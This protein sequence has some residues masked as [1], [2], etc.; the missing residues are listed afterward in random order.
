M[1]DNLL[2][3]LVTRQTDTPAPLEGQD[4]PSGEGMSASFG[5]ASMGTLGV[6]LGQHFESGGPTM[7]R[8]QAA[9]VMKENGYDASVL[10]DG[11]ISQG[12][13]DAV[14]KQQGE[15]QRDRDMAA[16]AH[17]G[18]ATQFVT[19]L[20]GSMTDPIFLALG[21]AG[22]AIQA[23]RGAV[24]LGEAAEGATLAV[25]A[26]KGAAEGGAVIGGYETTQKFVGTGQGDRDI[27]TN[28]IVRDATIGAV[29]GGTL[30]AAFGARPKPASDNA[31][32]SI[33][34]EEGGKTTD[35]GGR[36]NFGI[37]QKAHPEIDIDNLTVSQARDI[38][39]T[40][41]WDKIGGD[42]LPANMQITAL[43]AAVN[44]GTG[45]A[46]LWLKEANGDPIKFNALRRAD[47]VKLA[48]DQPEVYGKYLKGWLAR[49]GRVSLKSVNPY[50]PEQMGPAESTLAQNA[51]NASRGQIGP[52]SRVASGLEVPAPEAPTPRGEEIA[53]AETLDQLGKLKLPTL[54]AYPGYAPISLGE[55]MAQLRARGFD[56]NETA[57][58]AAKTAVL[59]A[60]QDSTVNV[61]PLLPKAP[62][63][64]ANL[65][66]AVP[67]NGSALVTPEAQASL[68]RVNNAAKM[69]PPVQT[70][71]ATVSPETA[72][73]KQQ[74]TEAVAEAE[75]AHT[76][77]NGIPTEEGAEPAAPLHAALSADDEAIA[78]D[79]TLAKA[80]DAAVRCGSMKGLV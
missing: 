39:K 30:G 15:I 77:A 9:K 79:K 49:L 62:G 13:L 75:H 23:V 20:A 16:R 35:T 38:Y 64:A 24:G 7:P 51:E 78:Q 71:N 45:K 12:Y 46:I 31:I 61:D 59:Q 27:T 69:T 5:A 50:F 36:T 40:E 8:D 52:A 4:V 72:A 37:S 34:K 6:S 56:M 18:G 63:E 80:V 42:S 22:K 48:S 17:L 28:Q 33:L 47:Y 68:E 57:T 54:T 11:E 74:A 32:D 60:S 67:K 41:Y 1:P 25:R 66:E 29:L 10:P 3:P 21:P 44:Q 55:Q 70:E 14:M 53:Q 2:P 26:A 58:N 73:L 19:S 76:M 43:D 65:S